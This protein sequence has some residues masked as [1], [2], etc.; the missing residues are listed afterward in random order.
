MSDGIQC[1]G[2]GLKSLGW[3]LVGFAA[4]A[5]AL[6]IAL[7]AEHA[8]FTENGAGGVNPYGKVYMRRVLWFTWPFW[9][10]AA[11]VAGV[12]RCTTG[13]CADKGEA[14]NRNGVGELKA[15]ADDGCTLWFSLCGFAPRE[16]YA[17]LSNIVYLG[18]ALTAIATGPWSILTGV[19]VFVNARLAVSSAWF[20]WEG[21]PMHGSMHRHDVVSMVSTVGVTAGVAVRRA[22]MQLDAYFNCNAAFPSQES[23][24]TYIGASGIAV[25][26]AVA[27][28]TSAY[29]DDGREP[30]C[31]AGESLIPATQYKRRLTPTKHVSAIV[32][33]I[34][35]SHDMRIP[36]DTAIVW[37]SVLILVTL[38][39]CRVFEYVAYANEHAVNVNPR[40]IVAEVLATL[41]LFVIAAFLNGRYALPMQKT[42]QEECDKKPPIDSPKRHEVFDSGN[43]AWHSI[44]AIASA[45]VYQLATVRLANTTED[46]RR[47]NAMLQYV[48]F[49]GAVVVC[50]QV[51]L[52]DCARGHFLNA[53]WMMLA[54]T[55]AVA[56]VVV[57]LL[58]L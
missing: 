13:C 25:A 21:A 35:P 22:Q 56:G 40:D 2:P 52:I 34:N 50:A 31:I 53:G 27:M 18:T 48:L 42:L 38:L 46:E 12:T 49:V 54:N 16:P 5:A 39:P 4:T 30:K 20:H 57:G 9:L 14:Y 17:T 19:F 7:F 15:D 29:H 44:S 41:G 10:F 11:L 8:Y 32:A 3:I 58:A 47:V 33:Y 23:E 37:L 6:V 55:A 43:G 36:A 24:G 28:A 51:I 26:L 1:C 45:V